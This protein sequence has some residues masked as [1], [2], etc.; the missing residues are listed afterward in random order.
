V[1]DFIDSLNAFKRYIKEGRMEVSVKIFKDAPHTWTITVS[2]IDT[3]EYVD[4][5]TLPRKINKQLDVFRF[6]GGI[7]MCNIFGI[8]G[9]NELIPTN[10]KLECAKLRLNFCD[11]SDVE[12]FPHF[13][14]MTGLCSGKEGGLN[15]MEPRFTIK[16]TCD[17]FTLTISSI[18]VSGSIAFS[19][20]GRF[21]NELL[22]WNSKIP[23]HDVFRILGVSSYVPAPLEQMTK[24][25]I[26]TENS[27]VKMYSDKI[28]IS[29]LEE[30]WTSPDGYKFINKKYD[31]TLLHKILTE[32]RT[33]MTVGEALRYADNKP[34]YS[35][36]NSYV[37]RDATIDKVIFHDPA[38]I[39]YWKDGTKTVVKCGPNDTYSKETGLALCYMKK[40]LGN[41]G[42]YN[43]VFRK[44]IK[45]EDH[46]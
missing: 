39:V 25:W 33:D 40:V 36:K 18:D 29:D 6:V 20:F 19:M 3:Y 11:R 17:G 42:N 44:W 1:N 2:D 4:A 21:I 37:V 5:G 26:F 24:D 7:P 45:E 38:T 43:D 32:G 30:T 31:G 14:R 28:V 34:Y 16:Q 15:N 10:I 8:L 35:C 9:I 22:A 12:L 23:L 41:K 46:D 13:I 27:K